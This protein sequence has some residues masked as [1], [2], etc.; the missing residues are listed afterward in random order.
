[1]PQTQAE[2]QGR[3]EAWLHTARDAFIVENTRTPG[4]A[5][6]RP[7]HAAKVVHVGALATCELSGLGGHQAWLGADDAISHGL[8][9]L[10][11]VVTDFLLVV[12]ELRSDLAA[13]ITEP[14]QIV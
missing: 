4:I 5:Q 12:V 7:V 11:K 14:F 3:Q 1:M 10:A 13:D 8:L 9:A 2:S 6:Q